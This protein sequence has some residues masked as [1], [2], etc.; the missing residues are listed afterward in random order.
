MSP[1][2]TAKI[3][4][5]EEF[6]AFLGE[7]LADYTK[8]GANWENPDL[9]RFLEALQAWLRDSEG[10]YRNQKIDLPSVKPWRQIADAV[11][12]ARNYE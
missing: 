12:A 4:T 3:S 10:Y 11:A 1:L 8:D 2:D 7:V 6:A 9:P 5:K